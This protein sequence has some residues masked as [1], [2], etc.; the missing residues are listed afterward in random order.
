MS[1]AKV[2]SPT[3]SVSSRATR[4]TTFLASSTSWCFWARAPRAVEAFVIQSSRASS[5]N[6][7]AARYG[8][9]PTLISD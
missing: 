3:R 1:S 4:S 7:M 5:G 6:G 8:G 9:S 2:S